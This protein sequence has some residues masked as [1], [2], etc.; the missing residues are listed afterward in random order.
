[1]EKP[2]LELCSEPQG[3][4]GQT[5]RLKRECSGERVTDPQAKVGPSGDG[6]A[7]CTDDHHS[8]S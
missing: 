3:E 6:R 5:E 7:G 8:P 2:G 1:M 4:S